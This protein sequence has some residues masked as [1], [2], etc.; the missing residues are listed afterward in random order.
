MKR[1]FAPDSIM[2]RVNRERVLLLGGAS[3][4]ILQI[5]HPRIGL[6]VAEHSNFQ[7]DTVGRLQR[8]LDAVY[9][10][11]FGTIAEASVVRERTAAVHRT[12]TGNASAAEV[13]GPP[14]YT[15]FE[16][17]AQ[18]WVLATLIDTAVAMF[19]RFV[20]PL[21]PE[22]RE[23]LY[24]EMRVF[25]EY[26]GVRRDFGAQ[27][28]ASFQD[29]YAEILEGDLLGSYSRSRELARHILRPARPAWMRLLGMALEFVTV[30]LL[31]SPVRERLG[32]RSTPL[33]RLRMRLLDKVLPHALPLLPDAVRFVPQYRTAL[34][35]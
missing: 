14:R 35:G 22:E 18:F 10:V 33:T 1:L 26:F 30:E 3:A 17:E 9:T 21:T 28:W 5:A 32:L 24:G 2:W 16:P 27:D 15:A 34:R 8:T 20:A 7:S 23:T 29:Y 25:G 4:A 31:P 11:A 13:V 6:A 12:V 19:E